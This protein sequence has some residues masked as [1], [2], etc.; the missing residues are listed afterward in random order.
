M[1]DTRPNEHSDESTPPASITAQ[2]SRS[3]RRACARAS[4]PPAWSLTVTPLRPRSP[5]WMEICPVLTA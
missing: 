4:R 1:F 2:S 5:L 3:W